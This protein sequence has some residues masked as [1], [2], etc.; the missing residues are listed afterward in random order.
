[1]L[2][3]EFR[4]L[5]FFSE[6]RNRFTKTVIVF[7]HTIYK[8]R[9]VHLICLGWLC[10]LRAINDPRIVK[11]ANKIEDKHPCFNIEQSANILFTAVQ[12][13]AMASCCESELYT[14]I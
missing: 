8:K 5:A 14:C 3:L 9:T 7:F 11:R 2:L 1:M 10:L 12:A 13:S 4:H 6:K